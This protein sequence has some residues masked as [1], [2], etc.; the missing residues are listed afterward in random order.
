MGFWCVGSKIWFALACDGNHRSYSLSREEDLDPTELLEHDLLPE[1]A[2]FFKNVS[3]I[4]DGECL[5]TILYRYRGLAADGATWKMADNSGN[6]L[7]HHAA[8]SSKP[9]SVE[10]LLIVNPQ[11]ITCWNSKGET[12]REALEMRLEKERTMRGNDRFFVI[13]HVSDN[14][15]GFSEDSIKCLIRLRGLVNI[16]DLEKLRLKYGCTCGRCISGFISPR[17][18]YALQY[19]AEMNHDFLKAEID[20][21]YGEYFVTSN[22]DKLK[23]LILM[24][25]RT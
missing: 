4:E 5:K 18:C 16:S 24:F 8:L 20:H 12:P 23:C 7:L 14:F 13:E 19:Q 9:L 10:W 17:M 6:T 3:T 2:S 21:W 22:E 25:A 11:L 1:T 15:K